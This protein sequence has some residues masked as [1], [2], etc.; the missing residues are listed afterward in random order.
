MEV[1][2]LPSFTICTIIEIALHL[3]LHLATQCYR[4]VWL[5][6]RTGAPDP[7]LPDPS[8]EKLVI[9]LKLMDLIRQC[10]T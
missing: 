10:L 9:G 5:P 3:K 6:V 2:A 4:I 1:S 8:I 7:A